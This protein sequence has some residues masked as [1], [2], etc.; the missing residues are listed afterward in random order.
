MAL[1]SVNT[2]DIKNVQIDTIQYLY[3]SSK[4]NLI[5]VDKDTIEEMF[6]NGELFSNENINIPNVNLSHKIK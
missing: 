6:K 3:D 5:K 4:K 1:F 2:N